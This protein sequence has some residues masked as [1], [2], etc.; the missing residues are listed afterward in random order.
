MTTAAAE[1]DWVFAQKYEHLV[2]VH[3]PVPLDKL[4]PLVPRPLEISVFDGTA[5]LGH[6]VYIGDRPRVRGLPE[7]PFNLERPIVTLRTLVSFGGVPGIYLLSLDAPVA[8]AGWMERQFLALRSHAADVEIKAAAE[9][10]TA[11]SQR[12]AQPET[13]LA[14]RY[15]PAGGAS[16]PAPG[17][18][19]H[20]LIGGDRLYTVDAAGALNAIDVVHG[21]WQ[22][23]PAEVA[24]EEDTIPQVAG[25]PGP[26]A[27]VRAMYQR[28]QDAFVAL[29]HRLP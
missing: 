22:L 27:T 10:V 7:L 3:W 12:R 21:P 2:L 29:P 8:F 20:F 11:R 5:W 18:I 15:R 19:D 25:L 17:S 26:G 1:H 14:A 28:T 23:A 9:I 4:R 13:R 16:T 6:D 24:F